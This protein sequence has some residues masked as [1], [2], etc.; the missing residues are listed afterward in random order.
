MIM[1][2]KVKTKGLSINIAP[3]DI[4]YSSITRS[5]DNY[6]SARVV[7]KVGE[8]AYL[9]IS[10]EW[11]GD[12]IPSFAMDLMG[13]LKASKIEPGVVDEIEYSKYQDRG[14]EEDSDSEDE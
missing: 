10:C 14:S 1:A 4:I 13:T 11:E 7:T 5:K 2:S 9:N 8:K 3:D 6:N 12:T